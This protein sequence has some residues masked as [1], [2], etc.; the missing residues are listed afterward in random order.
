MPESVLG[1]AKSISLP[2]VVISVQLREANLD[3]RVTDPSGLVFAP[4]RLLFLYT[5]VVPPSN[6]Y[7]IWS[8][9]IFFFCIL[10]SLVDSR[11]GFR[12]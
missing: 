2:A 7:G 10:V 8:G 6:I 3:R 1:F 4:K 11:L 12:D 5:A 9:V